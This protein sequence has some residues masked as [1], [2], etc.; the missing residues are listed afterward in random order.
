MINK[1]LDISRIEPDELG[2]LRDFAEHTFRVAWQH[3][4]EPGHFEAYCRTAFTTEK[5]LAEMTAPG[6]EFYFVRRNGK[7]VAY[8]KLKLHCTPADWQ[9][10]PALQLERIYVA[11]DEQGTGLGSHLLAFTETRARATGAAWVWLSVWQK[12]PRSVA[13]YQKNGYEIF[14]VETFW[15]GD[16]PQSDWLMRKKM[17]DE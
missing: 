17:S 5:L 13:F 12:A 4:N 16:D 3:D 14:G 6:A 8:L 10:G 2:A 7:R 9:E 15:I 11:P 1:S